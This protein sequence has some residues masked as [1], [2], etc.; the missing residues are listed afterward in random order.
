MRSHDL[1]FGPRIAFDGDDGGSSGGGGGGSF[2]SGDSHRGEQQYQDR[3]ASAYGRGGGDNGGS[4]SPSMPDNDSAAN[5]AATQADSQAAENRG[6]KSGLMS[7]KTGNSWVDKNLNMD[8]GYEQSWGEWAG[9]MVPGLDFSHKENP[10]TMAE[11]DTEIGIN[12]GEVVGMLSGVPF[13]SV[14]GG[15]IADKAGLTYGP[16]NESMVDRIVGNLPQG[17]MDQKYPGQDRQDNDTPRNGGGLLSGITSGQTTGT[18]TG[19]SASAPDISSDVV[20][21]SVG[22]GLPTPTERFRG[23]RYLGGRWVRNA[24]TGQLEWVQAA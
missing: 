17:S 4:S 24:T 10:A 13:G 15:Y 20:S 19:A 16:Q 2:T 11:G 3:D 23:D 5:N 1:F 21:N 8:T 12:P 14:I 6:V 18:S 9:S 22:A 7:P